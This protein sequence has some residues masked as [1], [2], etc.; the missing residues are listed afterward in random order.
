MRLVRAVGMPLLIT[1]LLPGVEARQVPVGQPAK[2]TAPVVPEPAAVPNWVTYSPDTAEFMVS[3]PVEP[4]LTTSV[5]RNG[6][7]MAPRRF[8]WVT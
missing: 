2:A 1:L 3:F 5:L 7:Q 4:K 6:Q 8:M